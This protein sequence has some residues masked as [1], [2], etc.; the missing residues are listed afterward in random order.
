MRSGRLSLDSEEKM[1]LS[2]TFR[3]PLSSRH[4][5]MRPSG[6]ITSPE[7]M[8]RFST[9]TN[10][11]MFPQHALMECSPISSLNTRKRLD[12]KK[13]PPKIIGLS[14][15]ESPSV[16]EPL[17]DKSSSEELVESTSLPEFS[18]ITEMNIDAKPSVGDAAQT[19]I[20]TEAESYVGR[21]MARTFDNQVY[22]GT[23]TK[24]IKTHRLWKIP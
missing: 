19:A 1:C 11:N 4:R 7:G 17:P 2:T 24:F 16:L 23:V 5:S 21:R 20:I 14:S 18:T 13:T 12:K 10:T 3:S 15:S 9:M 8:L 6:V 22:H